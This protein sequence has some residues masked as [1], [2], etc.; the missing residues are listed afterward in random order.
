MKIPRLLIVSAL[1]LLPVAPA[2][3]Q[4]RDPA[5]AQAAASKGTTTIDHYVNGAGA[6]D[7]FEVK[8]S[9]LALERSTNPAIREFAQ[10]MVNAHTD[11][12]AKLKKTLVGENV[13]LS[14]PTKLEPEKQEL[15]DQLTNASVED[16]NALYARLQVQGHEEALGLHEEY[17]KVGNN[18]TLRKFADEMTAHVKNHL[19][20]AKRIEQ[21]IATR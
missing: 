9:Q 7:L 17:A 11:S 20:Q 2:F 13:D 19:E 6:A 1:A 5:A 8:A 14:P 10:H 3:A 15:L 21:S 4:G 16:F 12:T 18:D